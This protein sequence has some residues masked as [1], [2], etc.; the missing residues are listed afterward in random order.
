MMTG[1]NLETLERKEKK[2]TTLKTWCGQNLKYYSSDYGQVN[3]HRIP[4]APGL[5]Q[6]A[7]LH[8][9]AY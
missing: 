4:M 9:E 2:S 5:T 6:T 1:S 8:E 7:G 3:P